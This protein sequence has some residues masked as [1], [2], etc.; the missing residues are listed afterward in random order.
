MKEQKLY[1]RVVAN[2]IELYDTYTYNKYIASLD[3]EIEIIIRPLQASKTSA[4]DA[5]YRGVVIKL[6]SEHTG[7]TKEEMHKVCMEQYDI[8]STA[9]LSKQEYSDYISSTIRWAVTVLDCYIP[10]A[11]TE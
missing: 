5:Y 8:E 3:G 7:Y 11:R 9:N 10:N 1:G 6:L 2:K 4:Q